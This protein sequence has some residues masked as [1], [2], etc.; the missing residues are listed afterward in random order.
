MVRD[1]APGLRAG[2]GVRGVAS[3]P[4]GGRRVEGSG[5]RVCHCFQAVPFRDLSRSHCSRAVAHRQC[6]PPEEE[7]AD[8]CDGKGRTAAP[9]LSE[10]EGWG[11][12]S[13]DSVQT[14]SFRWG[15][16]ITSCSVQLHKLTED[17][18]EFGVVDEFREDLHMC[19]IPR[20][21]GY[22]VKMP[23]GWILLNVGILSRNERWSNS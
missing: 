15:A 1:V 3:A 4:R 20:G 9:A 10:A 17:S 21:I 18:S 2:R 8:D 12:H 14:L 5:F 22:A 6:H 13:A 23:V 11:V 19:F 7:L 16:S